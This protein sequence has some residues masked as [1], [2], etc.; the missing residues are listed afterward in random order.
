M[1]A[2]EVKDLE[3]RVSLNIAITKNLGNFESL[4]VDVGLSRNLKD[5]ETKRQAY[6]ELRAGLAAEL[7][8]TV[9]YLLGEDS[10]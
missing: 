4:K 2:L 6:D 10:K 5:G 1:S 3:E 9:E 7:D 8:K